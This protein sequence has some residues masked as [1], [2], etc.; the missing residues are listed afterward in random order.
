MADTT[1]SD[2]ACDPMDFLS[3]VERI[4]G[5]AYDGLGRTFSSA[6]A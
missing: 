1:I 6:A 2:R 5:L 3:Q 4:A